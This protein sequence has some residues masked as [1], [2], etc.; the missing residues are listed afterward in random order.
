MS[1]KTIALTEYEEQ[2]VKTFTKSIVR[3]RGVH[4]INYLLVP[5]HS[6]KD[7]K[8]DGAIFAKVIKRD[9]PFHVT[10]NREK[11]KNIGTGALIASSIV[12]GA[13]LVKRIVKKKRAES[14]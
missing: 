6:E 3:N 9:E 13:L 4:G 1:E 8:R 5:V 14:E 12:G 10:W 7:F 2:A 11:A